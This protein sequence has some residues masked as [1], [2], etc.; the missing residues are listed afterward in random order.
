MVGFVEWKEGKGKVEV[1]C[2]RMSA[3][4]FGGMC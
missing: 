2:W 1:L 4:F 3:G